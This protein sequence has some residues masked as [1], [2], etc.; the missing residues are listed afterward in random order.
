MENYHLADFSAK[1]RGISNQQRN[2]L[3]YEKREK[4]V[5]RGTVPGSEWVKQIGLEIKGKIK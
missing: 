4:S 5:F 3:G 1:E 2:V